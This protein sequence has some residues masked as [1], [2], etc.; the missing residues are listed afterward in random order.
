MAAKFI[1]VDDYIATFPAEVQSVLQQIRETIHAAVPETQE[2]ISYDI[3]TMTRHGKRY[4]HFA[5][6]AK[7]VSLY[8]V[9]EPEQTEAGYALTAALEPYLA[10]KG[11]LKFPLSEPI[12]YEL[13]ARVAARL[14]EGP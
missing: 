9:P 1:D 12:P 7:H 6:W 4:V 2:T 5:G 11:T 13:I 10:G 14:A 3:P 8:P